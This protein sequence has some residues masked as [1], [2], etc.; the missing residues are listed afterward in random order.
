M[1]KLIGSAFALTCLLLTTEASAWGLTGHRVVAEIADNNLT[2]KARKEVT[3]IIGPQQLAYWANWPD[4]IKSDK[5]WAHA[6]SYHYVNIPGGMNYEQYKVAIENT[7]DD[8]MYKKGLF[9]MNELKNNK[10]LSLEKKQE[11]LYFLIHII[12]DSHQPLHVGREE[13]LGGNRVKVQWFRESTNI[14]SVWDSKLVDYEN[15]SFTEYSNVIDI[16]TQNKRKELQQGDFADW[17]YE[18]YQKANVIYAN[19]QMDEK[20][21]YKYHFDNK[22]IIEDQL[23]KGGVRLA[24]VLNDI[25]K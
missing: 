17:I 7:S 23:L 24:K 25:F 5:N 15:Y 19:V 20:L 4:F 14:H 10:E 11:Y 1:K 2:K 3:K 18:S 9:L 16:I 22:Y 8:N 12:G 13:D 6:D 21:G